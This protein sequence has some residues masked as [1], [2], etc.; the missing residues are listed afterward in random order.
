MV[1]KCG[2]H[3]PNGLL[4]CLERYI[5]KVLVHPSTNRSPGTKDPIIRPTVWWLIVKSRVLVT[6][7]LLLN[8]LSL[9]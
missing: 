8:P 6:S 5:P 9:K 3:I 4:S 7:L 1:P 2:I